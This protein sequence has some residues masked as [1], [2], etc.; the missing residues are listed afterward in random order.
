[1]GVL[2]DEMHFLVDCPAYNTERMP[3]FSLVGEICK[4]FMLM[5]NSDKFFWLLNCENEMVMQRLSSF[6]HSNLDK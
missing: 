1:M 6:V 4:N 3:F 2:G 5:N